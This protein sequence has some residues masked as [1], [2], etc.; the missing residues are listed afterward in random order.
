MLRFFAVASLVLNP[1]PF[2]E[3]RSKVFRNDENEAVEMS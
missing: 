2:F 1:D 3:I